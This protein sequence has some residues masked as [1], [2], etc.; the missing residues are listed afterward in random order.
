MLLMNVPSPAV[1]GGDIQVWGKY[2]YLFSSKASQ[3]HQNDRRS[4]MTG[5]S[6][7]G[8]VSS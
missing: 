1:S 6:G 7:R 5:A 2:E 4:L 3:N 8:F